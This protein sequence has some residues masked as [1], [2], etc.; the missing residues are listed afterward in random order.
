[1][2]RSPLVPDMMMQKITT[3]FAPSPTGY[4]HLG[5]AASA[6]A[7]YDFARANGGRF[8]L[9][10]EDIDLGRCRSEYVDALYEDLAWLGLRWETPVRRQSQHF[11]TYQNALQK[12]QAQNLIYP[13]FC[14]RADIAAAI[15]A[16]HGPDA[17]H[18][19]GTCKHL[20]NA[21][22]R[23]AAGD[24]HAWR[25][26]V[27]RAVARA[28]TLTWQDTLAGTIIADGASLG[29]VVLARKETPTS[30]HLAVVVDDALQAITNVVRGQDLFHA[31]HMHRLLQALLDLPT[32]QYYHHPLLLGPD[33]KRLAKRDASLSLR[34]LRQTGATPQ[35]IRAMISVR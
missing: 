22:A 9:R 15:T 31:T 34:A 18:Y 28:G 19:P 12:L 4:L 35:D 10:V 13:C 24:P 27:D 21:T 26:H 1:V 7:A 20:E 6:I 17:M 5:H 23:I 2:T 8:I 33:G 30:Y 32:P 14:S 11:L 3:R 29:D 16:P 25:L